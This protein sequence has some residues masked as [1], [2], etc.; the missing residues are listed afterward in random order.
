[1]GSFFGMY[2]YLIDGYC[3]FCHWYCSIYKMQRCYSCHHSHLCHYL[4][5]PHDNSYYHNFG[6][7]SNSVKVFSLIL[8]VIA[9]PQLV[10]EKLCIFPLLKLLLLRC[11]PFV[12]EPLRFLY[13]FLTITTEELGF[14]GILVKPSGSIP[15]LQNVPWSVPDFECLFLSPFCGMWSAIFVMYISI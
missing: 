9:I 6:L 14:R 8:I 2:Y 3:I 7:Y 12:N 4:C 11:L 13:I 15:V 1:M 5:N 10:W